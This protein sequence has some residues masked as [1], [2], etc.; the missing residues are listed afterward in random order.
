MAWPGSDQPSDAARSAPVRALGPRWRGALLALAVVWPLAAAAAVVDEFAGFSHAALVLAIGVT[1]LLA[2]A[3]T[4]ALGRPAGQPSP[5]HNAASAM[6]AQA[7]AGQDAAPHDAL[8]GLPTFQPFSERLLAEFQ[9]VKRHGGELAVVLIDINHLGSINEQFGTEVGDDVLR[10]VAQCLATTKRAS[11]VLTRLG[12]DEL[13]L[14]LI[15]SDRRG[16]VTFVERVYQRLARETISVSRAARP[17]TVWI[18]VCAGVGAYH[19]NMTSAD[20]ILTAAVDD[21]NAAKAERDRR[22][23]RWLATQ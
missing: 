11:D 16:A 1:G 13:G 23:G 18:G 12:D 5:R 10:R 2:S 22:R 14:L 19:P 4:F 21:L 9:R 15:E 8:T 3:L 17:V 6:P 7:P 20:D